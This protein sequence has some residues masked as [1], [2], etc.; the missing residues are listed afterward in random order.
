MLPWKRYRAIMNL[1]ALMNSLILP[2]VLKNFQVIFKCQSTHWEPFTVQ[3][4][5]AVTTHHW[6]QKW[7]ISP[8]GVV[9]LYIT[10][11]QYCSN[12]M[13][14]TFRGICPG[15]GSRGCP[16][17]LGRPTASSKDLPDAENNSIVKSEFTSCWDGKP[18][19]LPGGWILPP[20]QAL[21]ECREC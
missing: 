3:S 13:L 12:Q 10:S 14:W 4:Y 16:K 21:M 9:A 5:T 6:A 20:L 15:G 11:P 1:T 19:S 2:A 17:G 7:S 18:S 8:W